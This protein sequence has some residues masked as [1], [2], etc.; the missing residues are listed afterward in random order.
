VNRR[1]ASSR[2][3]FYDLRQGSKKLQIVCSATSMPQLAEVQSRL[4]RGDLVGSCT[5]CYARWP[6]QLADRPYGEYIAGTPHRGAWVPRQDVRRRAERVGDEGVVTGAV[7]PPVAVG[8]RPGGS[9]TLLDDAR[10]AKLVQWLT[11]AAFGRACVCGLQEKRSRARHVD[12]LVNPHSVETFVT[13]SKVDAPAF[14]PG[15]RATMGA[16][17]PVREILAADELPW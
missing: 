7:P 17:R 13:R 5:G 4:A 8:R 10:L 1:S 9:R 12:L 2:L 14:G 3:I 11:R 6:G 15:A 16:Y